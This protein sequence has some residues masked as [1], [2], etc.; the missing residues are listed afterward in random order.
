MH[1]PRDQS[2]S[3]QYP[4]PSDVT[5]AYFGKA[6]DRALDTLPCCT[7]RPPCCKFQVRILPT[8]SDV[9]HDRLSSPSL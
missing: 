1:I 2:I 6:A 8:P 3:R 9:V 7:Y 5:S 4:V